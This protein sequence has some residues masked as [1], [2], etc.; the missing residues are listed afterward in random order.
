MERTNVNGEPAKF[1]LG[2][3]IGAHV[4]GEEALE[5]QPRVQALEGGCFERIFFC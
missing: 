5:V 2:P 3:A 4:L 1:V